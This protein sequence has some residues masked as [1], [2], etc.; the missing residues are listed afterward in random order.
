MEE[1][2]SEEHNRV[3][4]VRRNLLD[5]SRVKSHSLEAVLSAL[6]DIQVQTFSLDDNVPALGYQTKYQLK[7]SHRRQCSLA[8]WTVTTR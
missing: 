4:H 5:D 3:L 6:M 7:M 8:L 2:F 1:G